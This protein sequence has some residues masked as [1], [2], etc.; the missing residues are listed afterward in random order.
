MQQKINLM[1]VDRLSYLA[2]GLGLLGWGLARRGATGGGAA[3]LGGWLLY[4]AYTG[5]NPMFA[6][7]GIQVNREPADSGASETIVLDEAISIHADREAVYAFWRDVDNLK[8]I[9][10]RVEQIDRIDDKHFHWKVE[11]PHGV[12]FEWESEISNERAGHEISWRT[13]RKGVLNHFGTVNFRDATG[14]RGTV[15]SVHLEYSSPAGSLGTAVARMFGQSPQR[16]VIDTL[17]NLKQ[18][19][20]VG[21]IASTVG[22]P[23]GADRTTGADNVPRSA[24]RSV[25]AGASNAATS[26][27]A[28][29][30]T[31]TSNT[32]LAGGLGGAQ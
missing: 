24:S 23:A 9:A 21:E 13:T 26:N 11:A 16:L 27:P 3:G 12:P 4:Q 14:D 32:G 30:S 31:A 28:T 1:K 22:Q 7:L 15:V 2:G 25:D 6:P 18:L 19:I 10:P 5:Y 20:E 17:R 29:L 8:R